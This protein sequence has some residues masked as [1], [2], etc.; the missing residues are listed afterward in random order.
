M[1]DMSQ[2]ILLHPR[3]ADDLL[4]NIWSKTNKQ[5]NWQEYLIIIAQETRDYK[6]DLYFVV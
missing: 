4:P 5:R 1:T 2:I 6:P 3:Y